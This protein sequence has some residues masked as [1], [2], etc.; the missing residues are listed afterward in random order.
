MNA[1]ENLTC[2]LVL[3]IGEFLRV[4]AALAAL[5][6]GKSGSKPVFRRLACIGK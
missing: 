2:G 3:R 4:Q 5:S 6:H 1:D